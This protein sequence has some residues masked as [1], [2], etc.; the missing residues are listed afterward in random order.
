MRFKSQH[1][2]VMCRML[3]TC[4]QVWHFEEY[5]EGRRREK[6]VSR[7]HMDLHLRYPL[8]VSLGGDGGRRGSGKW[9]SLYLALSQVECN[10]SIAKNSALRRN[11]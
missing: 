9:F 2:I 4:I 3:I 8:T 10:V 6:T 5:S 11:L 7:V 1:N